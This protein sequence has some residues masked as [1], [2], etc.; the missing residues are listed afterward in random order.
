MKKILIFLLISTT[1]LQSQSSKFQGYIYDNITNKP[2]S[3]ANIRIAGT[4]S[5]TSTNLEGYFS[6][7]LKPSTYKLIFS[8][9]GY[10][11]DSLTVA[12][13]ANNF[14][15]IGLIPQAVILPEVVV[16]AE[17]PAYR[18]IREAIKRKKENRK[19]LT[20][21]DYNCYSKR[22]ITSAGEVATIEEILLKGYNKIGEW[23]K[24]FI[25]SLHKN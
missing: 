13:P 19:G 4:T 21:F 24:E 20:N 15:E 12:I 11:S 8:Y 16:N 22:I 25:I 10:K 3:F 17:D 18:I 1:L 14:V 5:G 7:H 6:L 2:L 23:E 9:I